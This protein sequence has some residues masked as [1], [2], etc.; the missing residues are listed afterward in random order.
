MTLHDRRWFLKQTARGFAAAAMGGL[1]GRSASAQT[2]PP[3]CTEWGSLPEPP[4][5]GIPTGSI[6]QWNCA[7]H[8]GYKILDS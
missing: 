1:T 7:N 5:F 3:Q 8:P 6:T 4:P 2:P